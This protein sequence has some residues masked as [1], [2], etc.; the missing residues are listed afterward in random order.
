MAD[1]PTDDRLDPEAVSEIIR[2]ASELDTDRRFDSPGLDRTALEAA[3]DEVGISPAAVRRALAEHDAG[4]L[5]RAPDRSVLGPARSQAVRTVDLPVHIARDRVD[6]WLK[7]QLLAVHGRRGD[8]VEWRRRD[9]FSAKLRRRVDLTKRVRLSGVD[10]IVA[11]VVAAGDGRSI[12]RLDADLEHTRRGLLLG[13]VGV[14][15][16][17]TPVLAGAAALVLGEPVIFAA[18]FPAGAALGGAG[19]YAGRRTLAAER[20]EAA[21]VVELFLDDLDRGT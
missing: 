20:E 16:A 17:V 14:P 10:A 1:R 8:E 6:R 11:S 12:V 18:G 5:V 3:A 9:D 4:A 19:L 7:S 2:R 21:R 13:V 15:A